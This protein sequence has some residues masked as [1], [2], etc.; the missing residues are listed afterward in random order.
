MANTD[1]LFE[2]GEYIPHNGPGFFSVL[3]KPSGQ[4]RQDSYELSLLPAV[5][6]A[7]D[8]TIDTYITQAVFKKKNRRNVNVRSV[9]LLFADLDTYHIPNLASR[10]PEEQSRLLALFCS[11][12]GVPAPSIVL[13]SG[14]G[15]QAK[16]LLTGALGADALPDWNQAEK[17]LVNLLEPFASDHAARDI[18]RVLRLDHTTNTKSGEKCRI[19][20]TSSGV[21]TTLARYDFTELYENLTGRLRPEDE[22]PQGPAKIIPFPFRKN[23][24]T[25]QKLNWYRLYD[26]RDLWELRGGVPEGHRET[27]LFWELNFLLRAEPGKVSDAWRE[28]EALAAQI[29]PAGGWYRTSDLS[30]LYRKAKESR[31]GAAV[32]YRGRTYPPLY[33]PRNQTL[34]DLFS[35][36][37]DEERHLRT[38]ISQAEKYRRLVERRR[39]AGVNPRVDRSDKPWEK[40]GIPRSTWYYQRKKLD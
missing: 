35:I 27:T 21:E 36:T 22:D 4:A 9:G 37:S 8:P 14:R 33:T 28:A 11:E 6:G 26:L 38:I 2:P 20:F 3:A 39:S 1:D 34:I 12:E 13:F 25:L 10:S 7:A 19:V 17:A 32:L 18:S 30:T 16:W 31:T 29:D 24:F 15:L 40:Q 23:G 5:V